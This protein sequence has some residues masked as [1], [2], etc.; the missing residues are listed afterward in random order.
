MV[1]QT[2]SIVHGD[3]VKIPQGKTSAPAEQKFLDKNVSKNRNVP[4]LHTHSFNAP[5]GIANANLDTF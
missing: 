1:S 3:K 5:A 2:S 4:S